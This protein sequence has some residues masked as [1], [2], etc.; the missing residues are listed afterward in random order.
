MGEREARAQLGI[1]IA[2]LGI[3]TGWF[4]LFAMVACIF[5]AALYGDM[6]GIGLGID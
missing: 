2:K 6:G 3:L 1:L 4:I 5:Y